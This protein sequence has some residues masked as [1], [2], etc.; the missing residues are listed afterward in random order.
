MDGPSFA[1]SKS[2]TLAVPSVAGRR[3]RRI[4]SNVDLP[5]PLA[6]TSPATP[7]DTSTGSPARA[8]TAPYRFVSRSVWISDTTLLPVRAEHRLTH[9]RVGRRGQGG[10]VRQI[11]SMASLGLL[12]RGPVELPRKPSHCGDS[13]GAKAGIEAAVRKTR[14]VKIVTRA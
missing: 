5:A 7:V 2:R 4:F 12:A 8:V 13:A 6:P 1:T 3:P 9:S 11:E 10:R 14:P